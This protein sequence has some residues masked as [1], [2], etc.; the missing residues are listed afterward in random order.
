MHHAVNGFLP[1]SLT[2]FSKLTP[3]AQIF[4]KFDKEC[5][6]MIAQLVVFNFRLSLGKL[7]ERHANAAF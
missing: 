7:A 4:E 5:S 1:E 2:L 6:T 3:I